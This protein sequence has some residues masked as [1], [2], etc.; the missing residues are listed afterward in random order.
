MTLSMFTCNH[1]QIE[2][3]SQVFST[4]GLTIQSAIACISLLRYDLKLRYALHSPFGADQSDEDEG[5]RVGP[6]GF[7]DWKPAQMGRYQ[8]CYSAEFST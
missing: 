2:E 3:G 6:G 8:V 1:R 5:D 7:P 4:R